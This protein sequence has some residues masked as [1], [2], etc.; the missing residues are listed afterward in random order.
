MDLFREEHILSYEIYYIFKEV[1]FISRFNEFKQKI[2]D[3]KGKIIAGI[4][5][6]SGVTYVIVKQNGTIKEL[7]LDIS[8]QSDVISNQQEDIDV[9]KS[10]MSKTV[11]SSL[12]DSVKRQ[13]R[14]AEGKLN[15]ALKNDNVISEADKKLR[16]E[17]IEFFSQQLEKIFKAEELLSNKD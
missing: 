10:V 14:Y 13:L 2:K 9:L 7:K 5:F 16:E 17:E 15:N 6:V 8:K 3:N 4:I 1:V 11:L 12:K